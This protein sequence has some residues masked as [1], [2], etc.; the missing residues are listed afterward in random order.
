MQAVCAE[1]SMDAGYLAGVR[2][3]WEDHAQA[4]DKSSTMQMLLQSTT[5]CMLIAS[6]LR[7]EAL[8]SSLPTDCVFA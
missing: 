7:T 1:P 5:T 4:L 8:R 6:M 3:E 2:G